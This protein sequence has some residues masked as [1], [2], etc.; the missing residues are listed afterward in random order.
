MQV[1]NADSFYKAAKDLQ[2]VAADAAYP[3]GFRLS[4]TRLRELA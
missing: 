4:T 1:D 2:V 3:K